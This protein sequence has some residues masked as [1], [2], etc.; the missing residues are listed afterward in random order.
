MEILAMPVTDGMVDMPGKAREVHIFKI[1]DNRNRCNLI[2]KYK[3]PAQNIKSDGGLP[4]LETLFKYGVNTLIVPGIGEPG[5]NF[6]DNKIKVYISG[7]EETECIKNYLLNK[8]KSTDKPTISDC[9]KELLKK[10]AKYKNK[11]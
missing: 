5:L 4:M 7:G 1:S 9:S 6:L 10:S 2:K 8:L 3:N 11:I